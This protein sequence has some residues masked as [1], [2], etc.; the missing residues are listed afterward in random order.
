M[1]FV[2]DMCV[3]VFSKSVMIVYVDFL[4]VNCV[5]PNRN[6]QYANKK[7]SPAQAA[8]VNSTLWVCSALVLISD[9]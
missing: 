1:M 9:S 2:I 8:A 6:L 7:D 3:C 4:A 5:M